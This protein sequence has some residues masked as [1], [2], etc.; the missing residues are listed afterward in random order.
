MANIYFA[1]ANGFS[2]KTYSY[3]FELL[4]PHKVS[5]IENIGHG[6]YEINYNWAA[7]TNELIAD[8]ESKHQTA[9]VGI[10]HSLGAIIT[11]FAALKRPDLFSQ[12][13][14]LDPPLLRPNVRFGIYML[15]LLGLTDRY[16]V[17]A[18]KAKRRRQNFETRIEAYDYFK[19]K[20]LFLPFDERCLQDYVD[21]G[22]KKSEDNENLTLT[23]LA[24]KEYQVFCT[25]PYRFP[26]GD[27]KIPATL[28]YS[29][30]KE[31][32]QPKDVAFLSKK[33]KWQKIISF[34]GVHLFPMQKP[35]ETANLIKKIISK[36]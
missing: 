25:T 22:L 31:V 27:L 2:A 3:L 23:F 14:V 35:Q 1:H 26:K 30:K 18:K 9:V 5:Y 32:L 7:L 36:K 12:I 33:W 16:F 29:P 28:V 15:G 11:L 13:I 10:G 6:E 21:F 8:I 17:P 4:A 20:S 24:E 19:G 34:D